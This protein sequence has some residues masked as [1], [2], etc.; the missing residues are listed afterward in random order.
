MENLTDNRPEGQEKIQD[1][2]A[3]ASPSP[4]GSEYVETDAEALFPVGALVEYKE[5]GSILFCKV[6][7]NT[8][9]KE[10]LRYKLEVVKQFAP[11]FLCKDAVPGE[12]FEPCQN[13]EYC[14]SGMWHILPLGTYTRE[15]DWPA[16]PA[17]PEAQPSPNST[18]EVI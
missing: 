18:H 13:R 8:C 3:G 12:V 4:S 6:L 1:G 11:H 17:S 7:E 14:Y 10:W 5:D 2:S 16:L 15:K 9:D